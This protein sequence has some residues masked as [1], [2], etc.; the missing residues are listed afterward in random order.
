MKNIN[1][2]NNVSVIIPTY[3][4]VHCLER[5]LESVFAQDLPAYEVI[6]VD[7]GSTDG[8]VGVAKKYRNRIKLIE[9]R[10]SGSA[11]A[12]NKGLEIASG[13]F[14]AFLDAD[15]YWYEDF[16]S[17]TVS[18]LNKNRK[19]SAV[20]SSWHVIMQNSEKKIVPDCAK[21]ISEGEV[22]IIDDL[23][24]FYVDYGHVQTGAIL[25]RTDLIRRTGYMN[26]TLRTS[27][28][29]EYW[30]LLSCHGGWCFLNK[31]LYVNDS[32]R[33]AVKYGWR[34]KYYL[35]RKYVP[36]VEEWEGRIVC[37]L[38]DKS[39]KYFKIIRGGIAHAF[40]YNKLLGGDLYG[41][42]LIISKYGKD[43]QSNSV[44][45]IMNML[46]RFGGVGICAMSYI[47]RIKETL[48]DYLLSIRS[49]IS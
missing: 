31:V 18:V 34:K 47:F 5:A 11:V 41:A 15:D 10:N 12:R 6:I 24:K 44:T 21:V 45:C 4:V 28:D 17:Q 49:K 43:F 33:T 29:L 9:Q 2:S 20:L 30:F 42:K 8:T 22:E 32:R 23:F 46:S 26:P 1:T 25:I 40:A 27:Q 35:R 39:E 19:V 37:V 3:N 38:P 48:K 7:D 16:L 36:S 14:I 13:D